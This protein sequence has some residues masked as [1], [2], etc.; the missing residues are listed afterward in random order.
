MV[1]VLERDLG[2]RYN[3]AKRSDDV[4]L[5][6]ADVFIH[7]AVLG[8]GGIC[9]TLPLVNIAVGRRLGYPLKMVL[10]HSKKRGIGHVFSR[11][12]APPC[13]RFNIESA[14][15]G[16]SCEP[17]EYYLSGD[18]AMS[19]AEANACGLLKS[20]TPREELADFLG[21]RA[22]CWDDCGN[23][24]KALEAMVFAHGLWPENAMM[25]NW[26]RREMT[27]WKQE[28]DERKPRGFHT[29]SRARRSISG[30]PNGRWS[31]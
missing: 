10:A 14:G 12:D 23:R 25:R 7:G 4:P 3:P 28:L 30:S 13:D 17:D 8:D 20:L 11:W 29:F 24:P 5:E 21:A 2:V 15:R 27:R 19:K 1:T 18:F 26:I 31:G 6:T 22:L 16:L 9:G